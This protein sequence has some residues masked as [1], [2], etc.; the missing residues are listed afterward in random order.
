MPT[1]LVTGASAGLG[2]AFTRRL[3]LEH[4]DLILVARDA[5]RLNEQAEKLRAEH[6]AEVEVLPADLTVDEDCERVERRLADPDRP[7]HVLV[8]NAGV[9]L[10]SSFVE[11]DIAEEEKLLRLNVR[12]VMRL[13]H[14]VLPQMLARRKGDVINVSSVSGFGPAQPG[15]TYSATKAYVINF[16]ESIAAGVKGY[17]VRVVALCPGYTRTEF[18]QRAG[19]NIQPIPA[20]AWLNADDVVRE[21]LHDLRRGKSVSVPSVR[22]KVVVAA[23]RHLPHGLVKRLTRDT[24]GRIK[25]APKGGDGT[26]R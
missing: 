15:A 3:A 8:N 19:I 22:Y 17:G 10:N 18:H 26:R 11:A 5:V 25:Q 1:A 2:A 4:H 23:M 13:T 21:G 14:A 24:R 20:K 12:A 16:S 9:G 7:V 6:G